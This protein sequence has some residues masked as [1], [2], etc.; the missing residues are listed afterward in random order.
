MV[1]DYTNGPKRQG[2]NSGQRF[3]LYYDQLARGRFL[4]SETKK[5]AKKKKKTFA[6]MSSNTWSVSGRLRASS[7]ASAYARSCARPAGIRF[8]PVMCSPAGHRQAIEL[9]VFTTGDDGN[10][11]RGRRP[12]AR[13]IYNDPVVLRGHAGSSCPAGNGMLPAGPYWRAVLVVVATASTSAA[14]CMPLRPPPPRRMS[15]PHR[16]DLRAGRPPGP[17][18]EVA[19]AGWLIEAC[20]VTLTG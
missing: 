4:F 15:S 2:D 1:A 19:P 16:S 8:A 20:R 14:T 6:L 13:G 17:G 5:G 7:S 11:G 12:R 10:G 3:T 18:P 9:V